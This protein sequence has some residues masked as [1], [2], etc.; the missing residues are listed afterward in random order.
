M[1][2][3]KVFSFMDVGATFGFSSQNFLDEFWDWDPTAVHQKPDLIIF[4]G[5]EDIAT[6]MYGA[7]PID[8]SIPK[9]KSLRDT[10][11][12]R[13]FC[14]AVENNVPMLG[15]CRGAQLLCA[16]NGGSLF[17][18][19]NNHGGDHLVFTGGEHSWPYPIMVT[20][21]HHQMMMPPKDSV[22]LAWAQK[23]THRKASANRVDTPENDPEA[24]FFPNTKSLAIQWHPEYRPFSDM[25]FYTK[26][27]VNHFLV[28]GEKV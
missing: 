5:G 14:W 23:A 2:K 27:L 13:V 19:V 4:G 24:V 17:Q 1:S 25:G 11:E 26:D 7:I 8:K 9:Y 12:K 16:L 10:Y 15:I 6:E 22:L 3:L 20:S 28:S 21:T 18:D